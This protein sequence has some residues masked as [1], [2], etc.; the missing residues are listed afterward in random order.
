MPAQQ[1]E[2]RRMPAR[3]ALTE[4]LFFM[5]TRV[6]GMLK[7]NLQSLTEIF[8]CLSCKAAVPIRQFRLVK[9]VRDKSI[10]QRTE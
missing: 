5:L 8:K 2:T 10:L 7:Y 6:L 4:I 3:E 1:H 9:H